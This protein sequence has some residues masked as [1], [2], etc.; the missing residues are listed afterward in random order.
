MRVLARIL[1]LGLVLGAAAAGAQ[2]VLRVGAYP[3]NPPWEVELADGGF[4]G[5]EV[6]LARGIAERIGAPVSFRA[7]GFQEL[8][9][10][11][12][13][14]RIDMAIAAI[15]VTP[16]RLERHS[17]PQ[18]VFDA[19][20]A[21]VTRRASDVEDLSDLRGRIVAVLARSPGEAWVKA[22]RETSG[23][24]EIRS[25]SNARDLILDTRVGRADAAVADIATLAPT[26]GGA[27]ELR[28]AARIPTGVRLAPMMAKDHPLLDAVDAA[29]AA[30][31]ADG[32]LLALYGRWFGTA[33]APGPATTE[34][35][36]A[37]EPD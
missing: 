28:L 9:A 26:L 25:V 27:T 22:Q 29:I 18:P 6:D 36:P 4:E 16:R 31:K 34:A 35:T 10:A 5:F 23:I 37:P 1:A 32:T 15:A 33:V 19:D 3:D 21:M 13:D 14:G 8:L 11:T 7:M 24:A 2:P 30:M 12:A 20:L 17:F